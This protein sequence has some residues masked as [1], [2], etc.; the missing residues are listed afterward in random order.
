[1]HT[2]CII[3]AKSSVVL[4]L[5]P[6][7]VG[8][9]E[10]SDKEPD[11][12]ESRVNIT[13]ISISACKQ[14]YELFFLLFLKFLGI[15]RYFEAFIVF[16]WVFFSFLFVYIKTWQLT[17]FKT[18][19]EKSAKKIVYWQNLNSSH[20]ELILYIILIFFYILFFYIH[21]I[22]DPRQSQK[23]P[24]NSAPFVRNAVF[25]ELTLVFSDFLHEVRDR[26]VIWEKWQS[27]IFRE[28]SRLP[29]KWSKYGLFL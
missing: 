25:S 10:F 9:T 28:D 2:R 19:L 26:S 15:S 8:N 5:F 13:E 22:L 1:M 6:I 29:K 17:T 23:G 7:S 4:K 24:T 18:N 27:W 12:S 20:Y 11:L 3:S 21:S 16:H 14:I